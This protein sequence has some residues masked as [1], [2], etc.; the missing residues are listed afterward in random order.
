MDMFRTLNPYYASYHGKSKLLAIDSGRNR[1]FTFDNEIE[2][3]FYLLS[4][5]N[6]ESLTLR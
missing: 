1:I 4:N 6:L 3:D 2:R 5:P